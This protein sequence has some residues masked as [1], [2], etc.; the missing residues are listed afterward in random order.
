MTGPSAEQ[1]KARIS[2][3][4]LFERDGY[5]LKRK[6]S[7]L[8]CLSP[9]A[10]ENTP[11]CHVHEEEGWFKD[12]SSGL[13]GDCFVYWQETRKV[14]FKAA[15]E[16]LASMAG[17]S[18]GGPLLPPIVRPAKPEVVE[19]AP[20]LAGEQLKRWRAAVMRLKAN[21]AEQ[22]RIASWRGYKLSTVQWAVAQGLMG[23][24][25]MYGQEREAFAVERPC[26][27]GG[28]PLDHRETGISQHGLEAVLLRPLL[29]L[30]TQGLERYGE[31]E[32][33]DR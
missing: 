2:L 5:V 32:R 27:G 4:A 31:G 6:G 8:V 29:P 7:S 26:R 33:D 13:G 21:P 3:R 1:V 20:P 30:R 14:D 17:H 22:E 12:F 10:Q 16:A 25:R 23:L 15:L 9:F 28:A 24:V 18:G 11:S 19:L